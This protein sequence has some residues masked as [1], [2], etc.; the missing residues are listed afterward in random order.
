MWSCRRLLRAYQNLLARIACHR[1]SDAH[2][3]SPDISY[4]NKRSSRE[5]RT[6]FEILQI[7]LLKIEDASEKIRKNQKRLENLGNFVPKQI[8]M[9]NAWINHK[10]AIMSVRPH[11]G[12]HTIRICWQSEDSIPLGKMDYFYQPLPPIQCWRRRKHRSM[13]WP[14]FRTSDHVGINFQNSRNFPTLEKSPWSLQHWIGGKGLENK[15][16]SRE[17]HTFRPSALKNKS[18]ACVPEILVR[19]RKKSGWFHFFRTF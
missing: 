7:F 6:F 4:E 17:K 10:P 8:L 11:L 1:N 5:K 15:R 13:Q 3:K 18:H 9:M 16:S 14:N 19:R 12:Y 2:K